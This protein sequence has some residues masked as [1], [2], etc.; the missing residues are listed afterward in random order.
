MNN[1][2]R[3]NLLEY[4]GELMYLSDTEFDWIKKD[5][6]N[7]KINAVNI[8]I[9]FDTHRETFFDKFKKTVNHLRNRV[10]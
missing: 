8:L 9:G 7:K 10:D 3:D 1:S 5:E 4:L 2:L 6:L